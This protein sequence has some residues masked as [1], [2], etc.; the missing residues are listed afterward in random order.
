MSGLVRQRWGACR[1]DG[2]SFN[3]LYEDHLTNP[4]EG[5]S[6]GIRS[7]IEDHE[8]KFWL[9]NTW[10]RYTIEPNDAAEEEGLLNYKRETGID[11]LKAPDGDDVYYMSAVNDDKGDLWMATYGAGVW[12]YD[13]SAEL[14]TGSKNITH[15]PVE[16]GDK[17]VT[18]FSIHKIT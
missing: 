17:T 8:E 7:I 13:P 14:K 12:R 6:F 15:Y 5:G 18:L 1:Y 3:W 11:G 10:Y 16:N 9:C 4:P 2:K